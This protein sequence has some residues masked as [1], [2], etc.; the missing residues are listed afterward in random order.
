[1]DGGRGREEGGGGKVCGETRET[2]LHNTYVVDVDGLKLGY[3][4]SCFLMFSASRRK[5]LAMRFRIALSRR[6]LRGH[7]VE[8][9]GGSSDV[10]RLVRRAANVDAGIRVGWRTTP[11]AVRVSGTVA[12]NS[13]IY[14]CGRSRGGDTRRWCSKNERRNY[15][16]AC[17]SVRLLTPFTPYCLYITA[18]LRDSGLY[19]PD[20][21]LAP[22]S[23]VLY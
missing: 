21:K 8:R 4:P 5:T 16:L 1:M 6:V 14:R 20:V 13:E 7:G 9:G 22:S 3:F 11:G 2:F 18:F 17:C 10:V 23:T 19:L 12:S 15:R